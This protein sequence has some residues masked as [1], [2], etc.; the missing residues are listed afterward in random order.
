MN[1]ILKTGV[2]VLRPKEYKDLRGII[3]QMPHRIFLDTLLY[4][5][6]RY[7]EVQRLKDNPGWHD[8]ESETIHIPAEGSKKKK[9][10]MKER[11]VYLNDYGNKTVSDY[12]DLKESL[13]VRSGWIKNLKRWAE[14]VGID[15]AGL[16]AKTTRK[17]WESWLVTAYPKAI[18][19]IA[20]SQGHTQLT[21]MQ[22]YLNLPFTPSETDE[23]KK[24]VAGWKNM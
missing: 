9:R 8:K 20:M 19:L 10:T 18:V 16:C 2:R 12:L 14:Y 4:T 11:W 13:P 6:M 7:I 23:I 17:T 3:P 1:P 22:H 5:G 15:P 24:M 21:A